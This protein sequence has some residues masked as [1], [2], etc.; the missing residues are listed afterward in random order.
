MVPSPSERGLGQRAGSF[1]LLEA[2]LIPRDPR[3]VVLACGS[4]ALA[5]IGIN[6]VVTGDLIGFGYLLLAAIGYF[7]VQT[8]FVPAVLWLVVALG[9]LIGATAG[10]PSNWIVAGLG[11]ILSLLSIVRPAEFNPPPTARNLEVGVDGGPDGQVEQA[12]PTLAAVTASR[13]GILLRT[14]GSLAVEVDGQNQIQRLRN[15]PRLEF[16]LSYLVAR[17]VCARDVAVDRAAIAEEMALGVASTNQRDRLRKTLHAFQ[18][19]LGSDLK[20]LVRVTATQVRLDLTAV[21]VDFVALAE[22]ASRVSRR[23]GLIDSSLAEAVRT[24]LGTTEGEFLAGFSELEHQV[25]GGEGTAYQVVEDARLQI[26]G[27]RADL[28]AALAR[29]LEAAG[30][31]QSSI[32]YLQ[33]ALAQAPDREDVARLLVAAYMQTGQIARAEAVRLEY[34]LS[35]GEAR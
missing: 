6:A 23:H 4:V 21:D 16:L 15:K 12:V 28:T 32:T 35:S 1:D 5:A 22:M 9:G 13:G 2:L 14:I 31:A 7:F 10:N 34:K 3:G 11:G 30:R 27:W 33:S 25:T 19:A 17:W 8:R 29:H 20:R 24:L 26:A 18:A